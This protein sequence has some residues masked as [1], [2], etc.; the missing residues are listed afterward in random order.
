LDAHIDHFNPISNPANFIL[1]NLT[2]TIPFFFNPSGL[3]GTVFC[4]VGGCY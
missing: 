4:V 2:E 3:S 1:H